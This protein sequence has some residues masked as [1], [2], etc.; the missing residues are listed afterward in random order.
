MEKNKTM[1]IV[2]LVIGLVVGL[3]L[4]S[5]GTGNTEGKAIGT[6]SEPTKTDEEKLE[7]IKECVDIAASC[8]ANDVVCYDK[9]YD[10]VKRNIGI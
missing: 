6:I 10:C 1:L 3:I 4:G 8:D 5:N 7:S 2:G 9:I